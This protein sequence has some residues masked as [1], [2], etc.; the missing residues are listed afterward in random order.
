[1]PFGCVKGEAGQIAVKHGS[2]AL[3]RCFRL[4]TA[5]D[6]SRVVELG[7]SGGLIGGNSMG[8]CGQRLLLRAEVLAQGVQ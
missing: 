8:P 7:G 2:T 3:Q 4:L 6:V 5:V 1:M